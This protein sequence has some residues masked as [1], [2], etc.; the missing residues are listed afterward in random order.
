[1]H[2]VHIYL[3]IEQ[4]FLPPLPSSQLNG[5]INLRRRVMLVAGGPKLGDKTEQ[6]QLG[7]GEYIYDSCSLT[8]AIDVPAF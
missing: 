1:L 8:N 7:E 3:Y 2:F 5:T 6:V 4:T